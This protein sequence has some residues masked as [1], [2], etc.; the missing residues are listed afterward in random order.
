MMNQ[1]QLSELEQIVGSR[2]LYLSEEEKLTFASDAT[3]IVHLPEVVVEPDERTAVQ[4][5]LRFANRELIPVTPRGA[6]SGLSG[7]ALAIRGGIILSLLKFNRILE[8][9]KLNMTATVEPGVINCH[10]Q[11]AV[12]EQGLFYPPDP[13]SRDTSSLGGNVAEDAGGSRCYKYGTTRHYIL[14]L[15]VVLPDG[16][17]QRLG[18]TTR[19]GVVGYDLKDLLIGSEG[20]L[21]VITAIVVRLLPLPTQRRL[22]LAMY[23]EFSATVR[24]T[25][26]LAARGIIPSALEFMDETCISLTRE[27]LPLKIPEQVKSLL[28]V[29]LD[30]NEA[31]L[32][33]RELEQVALILEEEAPREILLADSS[34]RQEGLWEVRRAMSTTI[35]EKSAIKNSMDV[36]V[37]VS[38]MEEYLLTTRHL[39]GD[40]GVRVL[41]YGHL[42]DGNVHTNVIHMTGGQEALL[43]VKATVRKVL[44][45]ALSLGGTIS[46]E[47]GIGTVKQPYIEMEIPPRLMNLQKEIKRVFDPNDILNPGKIFT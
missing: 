9:D 12:A 43:E 34:E 10:L 24:A 5:L 20:T 13:A 3:D 27:E 14:A 26:A 8:I 41:H 31:E 6:G 4:E 21:G 1:R 30:G 47:H 19:K 22:L 44:E 7:G 29:E 40:S 28:M 42:A 18:V 2:N 46:G 39:G 25:A 23:D 33:D 38:R 36:V 32:I 15:D 11:D 17:F 37:P 45:I 35:K 16:S